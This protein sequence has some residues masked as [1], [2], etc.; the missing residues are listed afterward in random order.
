VLEDAIVGIL[1]TS[2]NCTSTPGDGNA[3]I[4]L[5]DI[6]IGELVGQTVP[7]IFNVPDTD[8]EGG[9]IRLCPHANAFT[10]VCNC[11][12]V[13]PVKG[14]AANPVGKTTFGHDLGNVG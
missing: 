7:G 9:I 6:S 1:V 13:V 12:N 2:D 3:D 5:V 10:A 4:A 8:T 14:T 11:A